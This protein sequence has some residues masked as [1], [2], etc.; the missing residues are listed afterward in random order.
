MSK[1]LKRQC[2]LFWLWHE[3]REMDWLRQMSLEGWQ[4]VRVCVFI[5][6]F[7]KGEPK[8]M[9]YFGDFRSIKG[10]DIE[11][12]LEIFRDSGWSYICR[13]GDFFYFTSPAENK[14]REVYSDNQSRLGRYR[15]L[16]LVH[17]IV[18]P[19]LFNSLRVISNRMASSET[20]LM[21][22]LMFTTFVLFLAT[23]YSTIRLVASASKLTKSLKE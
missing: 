4:L 5:Y 7:E 6:T 3:D 9:V 2:R 1:I 17:I 16:L 19:N 8:D 18:M 22:T 13:Q 14:Y 15:T 20:I 10:K 23:V 21:G 11:E 12:Y